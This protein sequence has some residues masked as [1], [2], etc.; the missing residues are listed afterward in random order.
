MILSFLGLGVKG[1]PSWGVMISQAKDDISVYFFW[2]VVT[3][4]AMMFGRVLA[5]NVVSDALQDAFDPKHVS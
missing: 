2:E 5:F 3:A 1:Q 4:S